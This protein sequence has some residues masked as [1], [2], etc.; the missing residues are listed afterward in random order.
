MVLSK[1]LSVNVLKC[2]LVDH[3]FGSVLNNGKE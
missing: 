2:L 3:L 1:V